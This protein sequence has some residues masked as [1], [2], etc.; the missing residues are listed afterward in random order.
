MGA[1]EYQCVCVHVCIRES[2]GARERLSTPFAVEDNL[3][4]QSLHLIP[5]YFQESHGHFSFTLRP[6]CTA[7]A[8][9]LNH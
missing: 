4:D 1:D 6:L 8:F 9:P 2:E 7:K 3:F 5:V